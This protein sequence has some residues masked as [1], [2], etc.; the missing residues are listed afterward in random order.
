[1]QTHIEDLLS[2]PMVYMRRTGAYGEG[3]FQLMQ[4]MKA[5]IQIQNLEND[6]GVIYGIPQDNPGNTPPSQCRYDVC[7]VTDGVFEDGAIQRGMLPE[8]RYLVC[9]IPHTADVVQRFWGSIREVLENANLKMDARRPTLERYQF[10]LV[11]KGVCE[12][13]IPVC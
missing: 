8:G 1:M 3:N 7:F 11:E 4:K 5:W 10:A 2:T 12:I 9:E 13:C 6:R